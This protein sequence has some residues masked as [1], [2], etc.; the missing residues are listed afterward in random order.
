VSLR[1]PKEAA[2]RLNVA[3]VTVLRLFDAGVLPGVVIRAGARK[4]IIRF[5]EESLEKFITS[6]E[7]K[8]GK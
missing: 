3:P 8:V 4:R 1:T 2:D 5:R 6:R 7:Q